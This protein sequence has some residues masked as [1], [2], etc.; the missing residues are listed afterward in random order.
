MVEPRLITRHERLLTYVRHGG[1]HSGSSSIV[2]ILATAEPLSRRHELRLCR[3]TMWERAREARLDR[4][5]NTPRKSWLRRV[6]GPHPFMHV[7]AP[8]GF[9]R[10]PFRQAVF[11]TMVEMRHTRRC[12]C[13]LPSLPFHLISRHDFSLC[14]RGKFA[15]NRL[16]HGHPTAVGSPTR[17][18]LHAE[19]LLVVE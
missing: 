12:V 11:Y 4:E 8:S 6:R 18:T 14:P 10:D 7:V 5:P 16:L 9:S 2:C 19:Q 13:V 17:P 3:H 1:I 15:I